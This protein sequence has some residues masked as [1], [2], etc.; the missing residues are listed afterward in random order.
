MAKN[1]LFPIQTSI[2]I[3]NPT[4][5]KIDLMNQIEEDYGDEYFYVD[6]KELY[7][8]DSL[9]KILDLCN[10]EML[11]ESCIYPR[12]KDKCQ[13]E[14][15]LTLIHNAEE[16]SVFGWFS[17]EY[18][19]ILLFGKYNNEIKKFVVPFGNFYEEKRDAALTIMYKAESFFDIL[20]DPNLN[21]KSNICASQKALIK[22][23]NVLLGYD[24]LEK[25]KTQPSI[26]PRECWIQEI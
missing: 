9:T 8:T 26:T 23:I 22:E 14:L 18:E 7:I 1:L 20:K 10:F 4:K 2:K 3:K 13:S 15:A 11:N 24:I 25:L 16:G 17:S 19:Q 12:K 5:L 6:P 21:S